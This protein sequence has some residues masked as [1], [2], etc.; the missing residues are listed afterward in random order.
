MSTLDLSKI[1]ENVRDLVAF[2]NDIGLKTEMSCEGHPFNNKNKVWVSFD[3]YEDVMLSFLYKLEC[4]LD[5]VKLEQNK[6]YGKFVKYYPIFSESKKK[7]LDKRQLSSVYMPRW[8]YVCD[9]S[10]DY[11]KNQEYAKNDL[12][13]FRTCLKEYSIKPDVRYLRE[14]KTIPFSE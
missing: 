14:D 1:E 4:E 8:Y 12:N 10:S 11:R 5:E 3:T 9:R 6:L 2:F 13:I 7:M